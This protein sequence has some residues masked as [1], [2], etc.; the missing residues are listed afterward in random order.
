MKKGF[1]LIELLAVIILLAIIALIAYPTLNNVI[2]KNKD[3]LYEKQINELERHANTWIMDRAD[4]FELENGD[5]YLLSFEELYNSGLINSK[6]VK[7]P[8][9]SE[10]IKGCIAITRNGTNY[11]IKYSEECKVTYDCI[12][13]GE[14][15]LSAKYVNGQYEYTYLSNGGWRVSL[16]DKISADPVT[17]KLCSTVNGKPIVSM[18]NMFMNSN[19][20]SIDL[21]SFDTSNVTDMQQMFLFAKA[22]VI[23]VSNFD[24]SNVTNMNT[25]F[26]GTVATV[27]DVSNFNTSKVT[28]MYNMFGL[29][30][31]TNLDLSNFDTS[32]VTNMGNMFEN[33][34]LLTLDL[35][36]FDTSKV[37]NMG[38]MFNASQAT[39]G[40]ARTGDDA[41]R[42]NASSGKP[43]TLVFTV[44]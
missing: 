44:K 3:K 40:Y 24:T 39:T 20:V 23:D 36:S 12:F 38:W 14:M 32:N 7:D 27:I 10:N 19:A 11:D 41:D 22:E 2:D 18:R 4:T 8:R 17:T 31:V 6:E 34:Q 33:S 25:M 5:S 35:S 30:Q 43:D 26:G 9:N 1:T 29:T 13:D 15:A 28:D 42:F 37:T 21:S 16:L